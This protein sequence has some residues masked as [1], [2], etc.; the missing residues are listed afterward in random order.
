L[1]VFFEDIT[2][3]GTGTPADDGETRH[4]KPITIR[5]MAGAAAQECLN[6]LREDDGVVRVVRLAGYDSDARPMGCPHGMFKSCAIASEDEEARNTGC[7]K[8]AQALREVVSKEQEIQAKN[9]A[10]E[11]GE[12]GM[13]VVKLTDAEQAKQELERAELLYK[14]AGLK[15]ALGGQSIFGVKKKKGNKKD[16]YAIP[17]R[18]KKKPTTANG[19]GEGEQGADNDKGEGGVAQTDLSA[20]EGRGKVEEDGGAEPTSLS[21]LV[22]AEQVEAAAN[23][24]AEEAKA[25]VA[26]PK[27][28]LRGGVVVGPGAEE[29]EEEAKEPGE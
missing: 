16:P 2:N 10:Y 27:A 24:A 19:E 26:V 3:D 22:G 18:K 28:V 1:A 5:T 29:L 20:V 14:A 12:I 11:S 23:K 8:I 25:A 6:A 13:A 21:Q 4:L 15:Q 17:G 7:M 9:A